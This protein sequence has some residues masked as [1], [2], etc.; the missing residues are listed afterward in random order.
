[1][2]PTPSWAAAID[3][4]T[5]LQLLAFLVTAGGLWLNWVNSR[6]YRPLLDAQVRANP[7]WPYAYLFLTVHNTPNSPLV[8]KDLR[9]ISPPGL[10]IFYREE[11]LDLV[12]GAPKRPIVWSDSCHLDLPIPPG[13]SRKLMVFLDPLTP[14]SRAMKFK[15]SFRNASNRRIRKTTFTA[16]IKIAKGM[17]DSAMA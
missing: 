13:G 12:V 9:V 3:V 16:S 8:L 14:L 1:M 11:R 10:W 6:R 2:I 17:Q 5:L 15:I 7:K 4:R